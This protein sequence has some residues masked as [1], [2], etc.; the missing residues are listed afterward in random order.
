MKKTHRIFFGVVLIL[1]FVMGFKAFVNFYP[2]I[3]FQGAKKKIGGLENVFRLSN[4]PDHTSKMVVKPNPDFMYV[5]CFYNLKNGPLQLTA[6]VS[7]TNYWSIGLYEPN[8]VNF[9]V[10]NY[11]K[12]NSN[13]LNFLIIHKGY[14]LPKADDNIEVIK[15]KTKKGLILFRFLV[16]SND[17]VKKIKHIQKSIQIKQFE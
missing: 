14:S 15:S 5:S 17:D 12:F 7:N 10:K 16:N 3:L 4:L 2:E 8:T 6:N 13:K 9:Y 11:K 1:G